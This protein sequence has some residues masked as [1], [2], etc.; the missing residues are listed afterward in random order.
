[1]CGAGSGEGAPG[2]QTWPSRYRAARPPCMPRRGRAG[3]L[4]VPL[5]GHHPDASPGHRH[6]EVGLRHGALGRDVV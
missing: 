3:W 5:W 4:P 2:L 6:P 1:M